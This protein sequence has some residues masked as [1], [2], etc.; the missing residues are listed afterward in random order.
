MI[1]HDRVKYR[2]KSCGERA[3]QGRD[4]NRE[5]VRDRALMKMRDGVGNKF[6]HW[7]K[8][9]QQMWEDNLRQFRWLLMIVFPGAEYFLC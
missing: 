5:C 4:R 7:R 6:D 1:M 8:Y 3:G 2:T 9:L